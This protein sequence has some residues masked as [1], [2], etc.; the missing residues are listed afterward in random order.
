MRGTLAALRVRGLLAAVISMSVAGGSH[1]T[2]FYE[3][4]N[5][6][7]R[8]SRS[9][10][11]LGPSLFGDKVNLYTGTLEFVQG[12]LSL[13]GNNAL[14]VGVSRKLATGP[15]AR[16]L[17]GNFG[18]WDL[19]IPRL[20]G[21]FSK[22][23]GWMSNLG[24]SFTNQRCSQFASP[25]MVKG[26]NND[27]Y[28]NAQEYWRGHMLYDPAT[29]EQEVLKRAPASPPS[30]TDGNSYPLLT[31][32]HWALRCGVSLD[33]RNA[34]YQAS[35]NNQ[36]EGFWA[37]SPDGVSYRFDWLV[38]RSADLLQRP[39]VV[40]D[41]LAVAPGQAA[42][43]SAAPASVGLT[44]LAATTYNLQRD[45]VWIL[46]TLARDRNGNTVTYSYDPAK[47]WRLMTV[48]SSDDRTLTFSYDGDSNRVSSVTDG[49]RTV[50]YS[51]LNG[52]LS[53]V[54]YADGSQM[55]LSSGLP[56]GSTPRFSTP[57]QCDVTKSGTPVDD[58]GQLTFTHPSGATG[59]FTV[60]SIGHAR[61]Y[62]PNACVGGATP[63]KPLVFTPY[64]LYFVT[65]SLVGK[66]IS[67]PGLPS[68]SWTYSYSAAANQASWSD[69]TGS[70][71]AT[72]TVQVVESSGN[73]SRQTLVFGNRVDVDEGKL[74][75]QSEG[76]AAAPQMRVTTFAYQTGQLLGYSLQPLGDTTTARRND[77]TRLRQIVQSGATFKW[78]ATAFD[79]TWDRPTTVTRSGPG[80][81]I[82]EVTAYED[83]LTPYVIGQ[84]GS[85]TATSVAGQPVI[86]RHQY[87][88]LGR[89]TST[90]SFGVTQF[91]QDYYGDGTLAWR[92][93][94][95]GRRTNYSSYR[96]GLPQSIS[97]PDGA[98]E[99][100]AV[101]NLGLVTSL[102]NA[103]GYTTGYG[104]DAAGRLSSIAPP[105]GWT[106]TYLTFERV[107]SPE[108][109]IP[110][111]H[112]RQTISQGNARTVSY[113]DGFWRP[114]I[115]RTFD[116]TL[117]TSTRKVVVKGYDASGQLAFESYPQRDAGS[118][119]I[120][121][122]GKRMS[123]DA[124]GRLLRTDADSELGVITSSQVYLD[125]FQIQF[126]NP[127]GKIS[128]QSYWA[129]DK[130]DDAKLATAS[131][132]EGV[133]VSISRD[134]FGKPTSISRGGV[135]RSYVYDAGQRLCKTI[136]PEIKATVQDYDL[137]G[138]L[139]WKAPG[140]NLTL[141]STCDTLSVPAAAK[142]SYGYDPMNRL[143]ST[144]YGDTSP[145]ITREY[146]PDGKLKTVSSN[147]SSWSYVY[148]SL[149][150]ISTETLSYG[151]QSWIFAW[152]YSPNGHLASLSYPTGGPGVSYVPNALG[153]PSQVGSFATGL[154]FHPNGAVNSFR[155]GNGIQHTLT[156]NLRGLPQ[157]N[158]DV[159]VM[160]DAYA[161]DANGN[162]NSI[163]DQQESVFSRSMGYDD[164]DRLTSA[165]A[166]GVWGAA[167]YTYDAADNL[168]TANVGSR[169]VTLNYLDGTNRLNRVDVNGTQQLYDYDPYG[170]I[171]RKGAQQYFF[172]QGNRLQSAVPGGS[173]VYDGLGRRIQVSGGGDGST[174]LS[175]YSQAGQL[176]WST[177]SGGSRPA[178]TTA[179]V[180]L[181]GKAIA[182]VNS[183]SGTQYVHTDALGS[184]VAHT[185]PTGT[186]LNRTRYEPYGYVA[187]GTKP[188]PATSLMGYTGH[189]QDA[190]TELVYMQQRY[191]DPI[192][193]RFLSVDPVVT[194][195]NTGKGFGLYTYV[196]NNPYAKIDPDGR[197]PKMGECGWARMQCEV[198]SGGG[199]S[200]SSYAP[201]ASLQLLRPYAETFMAAGTE[202]YESWAKLTLAALPEVMLA[203][204]LVAS[205]GVA[206]SAVRAVEAAKETTT[207]YRAV[208]QA[209]LK[210]IQATGSFE[211]G[212][213]SLGGKWL[214]ETADHARQWGNVMNGKGASTIL[215]VQLPR[216]QADKLMRMERLD[217]IGP[218]RYGELEQLRGAVIK[219]LGL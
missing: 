197:E 195:A 76:S 70:C 79:V 206:G 38:L 13:P 199:T 117:E 11:A 104:Y 98:S 3:E 203:R 119:G 107:G 153:E 26:V 94:G 39:A 28:F 30:P 77:P 127:R 186:L 204:R 87:D 21:V 135:T 89:L 215:E 86:V 58:V 12:D 126:T 179:Y 182:E 165:S 198:V 106:P 210:Q 131:L 118:V 41:G 137:A 49:S 52:E 140:Q 4:Q 218:A 200:S 99:A 152:G 154:S 123:Y 9:V 111:N 91:T 90:A 141:T 2:S 144:S 73:Q 83:R 217:G 85:V 116:S 74:L 102:T 151:G 128:T 125:G 196:D 101:N 187:A 175:L 100:A 96:R 159:G 157:T 189:V 121:T 40:G 59:T 216:V 120:T 134:A 65:R 112:W 130:P 211:V 156:L 31:K 23:K 207:L 178:S 34:F 54:T 173:Y 8:A 32:G 84:V 95:A 155:F 43:G 78:E 51:Y 6:L 20:Q 108:Y 42:A 1:A 190:E 188:G 191:Y 213:N 105:S 185:G 50:Y 115:T 122:P 75:S 219:V 68:Q 164:L 47:P 48:S 171:K 66:S 36:G 136:E 192:A 24:T 143:T 62:V 145:G 97:Y 193:G 15:N 146:W 19:E 132:P 64:P 184:P 133:T 180:Y 148:N 209:E 150:L 172:D 158:E 167:T 57:P 69:C 81:S 163:S 113:F 138:N 176:L 174:R 142:I 45:E 18:G 194:D 5:Q 160:K 46:P 183:A 22:S 67:G 27:G 162:V 33:S 92:A 208:T 55:L 60:Q 177:S 124:L 35:S 7:I 88:S 61:S 139:S 44:P 214:A 37:V 80:G 17:Q 56:L 169:S 149:R 72:K 212:A 10:S 63:T 166:P 129:L 202:V 205:A 71:P 161:Y 168:K 109:G 25:G 16:L 103:A 93:D 82:T 53:S 181:A 110:A 14:F 29:G 170:N 201:N 147:G 114:L